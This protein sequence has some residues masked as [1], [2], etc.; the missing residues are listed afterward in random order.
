MSRHFNF[1][2]TNETTL[3]RAISIFTSTLSVE[4]PVRSACSDDTS[5]IYSQS[6]ETPKFSLWSNIALRPLLTKHDPEINFLDH[7]ISLVRG[8]AITW[9]TTQTHLQDS[10]SENCQ[11]LPESWQEKLRQ[12]KPQERDNLFYR[13]CHSDFQELSN[14]AIITS[15]DLI[16]QSHFEPEVNQ[17][18]IHECSKRASHCMKQ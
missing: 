18:V 17:L 12:R 7:Q 15:Q 1:L 11:S 13:T 3:R 14:V 5:S 2:I 10:K 4:L 6:P 8:S 16:L 9:K